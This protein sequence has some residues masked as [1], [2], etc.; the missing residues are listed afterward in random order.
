MD[1]TN[2]KKLQHALESAETINQSHV[3]GPSYWDLVATVAKTIKEY[4]LTSLATAVLWG[5]SSYSD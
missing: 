3:R 2:N 5:M 1:L 4:P